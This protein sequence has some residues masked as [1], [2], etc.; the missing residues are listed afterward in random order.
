MDTNYYTPSLEEFYTGF[1]FERLL[2]SY[3]Y[4]L[5]HI[6]G[7]SYKVL[8]DPKQCMSFQKC[9]C[10]T[11]DFELL[12]IIL[13]ERPEE[14]RVK[15][16]D[17]EDI[18]ELGFNYVKA[19]DFLKNDNIYIVDSY[20]KGYFISGDTYTVLTKYDNNFCHIYSNVNWVG[21]PSNM[22][23]VFQG[24]IKNKSELKKLIEQLMI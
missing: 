22:S 23:T 16:L 9:V 18:E 3:S 6:E 8:E 10:E 12:E 13:D 7:D 5:Q 4:K 1:E 24:N 19:G 17:R 20:E 14:V 2:T 11:N 15:Y 21:D